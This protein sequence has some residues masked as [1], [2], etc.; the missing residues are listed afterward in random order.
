MHSAP[1]THLLL[2]AAYKHISRKF[3]LF[4][5]PHNMPNAYTMRSAFIYYIH[6]LYNIYIDSTVYTYSSMLN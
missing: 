3:N 4:H 1:S 6:G 2:H 5:K